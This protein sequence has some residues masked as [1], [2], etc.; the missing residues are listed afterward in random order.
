MRKRHV[1]LL[2][3][4]STLCPVL[5]G[6]P[7]QAE[8]VRKA[9]E[10]SM[11]AYG[12]KLQLAKT[13]AERTALERPS[14]KAAA[15]RM[16]T[17][18]SGD[19]AQPWVI[20]PA[21]WFLRVAA[22]LVEVDEAGNAKSLFRDEIGKVEA[23]VAEHHLKSEGLV[24]MCMAL[25]AAGDQQALNV[26][27]AI[28]KE[29]PDKEVSG[30]AA[31][32]VAMVAKGLGD[33]GQVMRERLTML[34]QAIIDAA[35]VKIDQTTVAELADEE[36]YIIMNLSKGTKA[37]DLE[38][39]DSGGRPMKLSDHDGKVVLLVFWN[40]KL[41][42]EDQLLKWISAL[43]RDDRFAGKPFEVVG[44]NSDSRD[45]LRSMQSSGQVDW[46]N[47]SDPLNDLGKVYRVGSWPLAYVLGADRKIHYVGPVGTF[48]EVTAAA[49]LD[50]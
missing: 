34:R 36:L 3:L 30:T 21:S 27:R 40:T 28:V 23:A 49:V 45:Q 22:P 32:G 5:G 11:E 4:L 7:Q 9:Y 19:L 24:P 13:E 35:D 48:A 44:V 12:L 31:L 37:P 1:I 46:P 6:S 26:L 14:A 16:W 10:K 39:T 29:N 15:E 50:E 18:I 25:V 8:G 17:A 33:E 41:G 20:E 47:F 2:F 38:G 42:G 43:R